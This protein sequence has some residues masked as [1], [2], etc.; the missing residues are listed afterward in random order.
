VRDINDIKGL[1]QERNASSGKFASLQEQP[2][3]DESLR[4]DP[5]GLPTP[6]EEREPVIHCRKSQTW[7]HAGN[8]TEF[9]RAVVSDRAYTCVD[10]ESSDVLS[11]LKSLVQA[12]EDPKSARNNCMPEPSELTM[13]PLEA[14]LEILRWAKGQ[15]LD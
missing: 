10:N 4:V 13:P 9:V 14:I 3:A 11:S 12:L 5:G 1:L 6:H 7:D 8:I 2:K 15:S